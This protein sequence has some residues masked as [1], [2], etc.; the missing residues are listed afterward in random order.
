MIRQ[1]TLKKKISTTG[2]GLHTG[3]KVTL[4]LRPAAVDT[5]RSGA[6]DLAALVDIPARASRDRHPPVHADRAR[7]SQGLDQSTW[8]SAF[9]GLGWTM[10][11]STS[12]VRRGADHGRQRR[13]VVFL[14]QQAGMEEQ[15]AAKRFIRIKSLIEVRGQ[16]S[17]ALRA[18][19]NGFKIDFDRVP[20]PAPVPRTSGS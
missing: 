11:T 7:W 2:V 16:T 14:L 17:G 13:A 9:A 4:T 5:A 19:H 3:T 8:M 12:T 6:A 20:H 10:R 18:A 1:R 15:K